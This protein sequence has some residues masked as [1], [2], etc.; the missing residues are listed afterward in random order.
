MRAAFA[1][2]DHLLTFAG[3]NVLHAP[4]FVFFLS[5]LARSPPTKIE[6]REKGYSY[7]NS[8]V[9]DLAGDFSFPGGEKRLEARRHARQILSCPD[10]VAMLSRFGAKAGVLAARVF[11]DH[12]APAP[13]FFLGGFFFLSFFFSS[14]FFEGG[15]WAKVRKTYCVFSA[16]FL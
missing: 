11:S 5:L 9:E 10:P 8:L 7:S 6:C 15:G 4:F 3:M 12:R 16:P 2:A 14:F 1:A 13:C